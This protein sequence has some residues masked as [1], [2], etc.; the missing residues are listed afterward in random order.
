MPANEETLSVSSDQ[1][2]NNFLGKVCDNSLQSNPARVSSDDDEED[3]QNCPEFIINKDNEE[4][5]NYKSL[6][7]REV[8]EKFMKSFVDLLL[9]EAVFEGTSRKNRVVEWMEPAALQSAIDL[10]LSD[11]GS[12]HK[13]LATLA[14]NIIKYSVKTGH[15]RFINQ[16]YS[17]VDPYGLLGQWLTDALN[18]SVYT[19]EVSPVFSL[20]E[21]EVLYEMRKIVGWKDGRGEGIFCPGGSIANGY[22]INLARHYRF[23]ELKELGLSGAGRL[24]IFTSKDSHYSVKKLSAFLGLGTS[25]V[26][27]VKTNS[28]GKMCVT[29][30]EAQIKRA[31]DEDAVPLMV[32]ATAG[33]TVLGAFDPLKEIALICKKYNLWYHVDAAWGGGALM[34]KKHRHLLAGVELA[35]SVTWNPHK[36][37]AAPQQCSTLLLRHEGLLQAAHGSKASYL[38]Q[39]DKFYDTSFDS[40][41]K[42]IQCGR[43]ADVL[44]FWFMWKAK[45]T[46]GLEKH[47]DRVFE[48]ARYFTNYIRHREG[49]KLMLE[50]ECT[51]VCFWYVPPSKRHLQGDELSK[52][53]QKI[54]P[55]VKERM[56]KKGSMLITYQPLCELPNFFRLVLQNSGLTEADMRFFAEEIERLAVDL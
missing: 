45:G 10:K 1:I 19:Y 6:P 8:H 23:P 21:E 55:A 27:E 43:R 39:P 2:R 9:K 5:C 42:H 18:P 40:G 26:Y 36:L 56:M 4:N 37:L 13:K 44:K 30:L 25:N 46:R 53:L 51:N 11:Q 12:S 47:V 33:T 34:S 38:F 17:S 54:G 22:A 49:F 31:L 29:D 48:L 28:T 41:D 3:C 50:P 20:M 15:P 32:S 24:I 14:R 52:A 35:D 7:V 16:L